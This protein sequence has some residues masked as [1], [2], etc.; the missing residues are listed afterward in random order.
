MENSLPAWTTD[1][2][3]SKASREH[4]ADRGEKEEKDDRL[5]VRNETVGLTGNINSVWKYHLQHQNH[6]SQRIKTT[7]MK[8]W[9][10]VS[11]QTK[12][13]LFFDQNKQV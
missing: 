11:K 10:I 8:G 3:R 9:V 4:Q 13:I 1:E 12:M 7:P 6:F 5:D 2:M